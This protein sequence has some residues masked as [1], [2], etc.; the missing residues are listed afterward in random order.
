MEQTT[1]E[2]DVMEKTSAKDVSAKISAL[3]FSFQE[4]A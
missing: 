2:Q 4:W 1:S 3:E